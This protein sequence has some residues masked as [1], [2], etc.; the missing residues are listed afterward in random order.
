MAEEYIEEEIMAEEVIEKPR[1]KREYIDMRKVICRVKENKR[2][3]YITLPIVFVLSC[4]YAWSLPRYYTSSVKLAPEM[5]QSGGLG[6][7]LGDLASSFG[8]DMNS[9][10][11]SDAITP[12]LYPDLMDDN[13]FV[14]KL[15]DIRVQSNF[16]P[17]APIDTTYYGYMRYY[18]KQ[19]FWKN[20]IG[21]IMGL[22]GDSSNSA[23]TEPTAA[24]DPYNVSK[25]E[26][27]VMGLIRKN[28]II[29]LDKKTGVIS[30]VV[31]AQD[32]YICRT[33]ADSMR[34]KLQDFITEYRTSKARLDAAHYKEL[35]D[36]A[37][38]NYDEACAEYAAYCDAHKGSVLQRIQTEQDAI[39]IEMQQH[40]TT[41]N[42]ISA[43]YQAALAKVQERTP[44]F[45]LLKGA[46]VP[47]TPAGPKRV[48]TVFLFC[49][50]A[51][52]VLVG[53]SLRKDFF[54]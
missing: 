7:A 15:Y 26:S 44:A 35:M 2:K 20:W 43:Q 33:V 49:F 47:V 9:M 48:I 16:N 50:L 11:T 13:A 5:E 10:E 19:P 8:F 41:Y 51:T 24:Y 28:V 14:A 46:S 29:D 30:I 39:E 12:L 36:E 34:S 3:F 37:K 23:S 38:A 45:T 4:I 1:K 42:T 52:L 25:I 22:F 18:Q 31:K 27:G 32:P 17:N 6:G 53:Y 54:A 21:A 40:L